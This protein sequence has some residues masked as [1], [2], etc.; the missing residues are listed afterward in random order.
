MYSSKSTDRYDDVGS[1]GVSAA[2]SLGVSNE[3]YK[4][5]MVSFGFNVGANIT[6]ANL[7]YGYW[8]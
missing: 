4:K 3:F 6:A 2:L 1:S 8:F 7:K 5:H